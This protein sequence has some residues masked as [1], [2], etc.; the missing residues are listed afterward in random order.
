MKKAASALFFVIAGSLGTYGWFM[1]ARVG[2]FWKFITDNGQVSSV[3]F[4]AFVAAVIAVWGIHSQRSI[5]RRQKTLELILAQE[6]DKD[7]ID[8]RIAFMKIANADDDKIDNYTPAKH[9]LTTDTETYKK[10]DAVRR[11]LN[12]YELISIG[13]QKGVIDYD[14]YRIWMKSGTIVYWHKSE[15]YIFAV[16]KESGNALLY[17]EFETMIGWL[18]KDTKPRRRGYFLGQWF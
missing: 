8:A 12:S 6:A 14:L 7:I 2:K 5:A 13:I 18:T 15:P 3:L 1:S 9:K 4:T 10:V 11:I 17:H 16:R